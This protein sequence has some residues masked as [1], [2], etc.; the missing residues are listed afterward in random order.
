MVAFTTPLT[1]TPSTTTSQPTNLIKPVSTMN[2]PFRT[3]SKRNEESRNALF[4]S[5]NSSSSN[6]AIAIGGPVRGEVTDVA[7]LNDRLIV[8]VDFG[9]TYSG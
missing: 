9:T 8:G 6:E 4:T 1:P 2:L 3:A 5:S 7:P